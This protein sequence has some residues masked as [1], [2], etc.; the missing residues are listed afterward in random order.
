MSEKNENKIEKKEKKV[1]RPI[2]KSKI[3]VRIMALFLAGC[4]VLSIAG[5]LIYYIVA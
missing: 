5:T 3:F 2:D 1:K 4:M